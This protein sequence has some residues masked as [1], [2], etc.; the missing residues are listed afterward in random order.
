VASVDPSKTVLNS[1]PPTVIIEEMLVDGKEMDVPP[2]IGAPLVTA[3]STPVKV[4]PGRHYVQFRFT[5]LSF[6]APDG[7]RFRVK[8]EGG[9]D[10][11]QD[12][13][14]R[15]EIGYGPLLPGSYRFR[16]MA[17]NDDGVWNQEG[18]SFAFTVLPNYWETRW[19]K[20]GLAL[21][22]LAVFATT[23]ASIQRQRYRRRLER[24]ERQREMEQERAR[25]ARDLHDDLGTS[26]TQIS[27]LTAL[28]NR[29]S[30][31][32][33]EARELIG[34]VHGRAREMVIALDEI[35]WAV[36]PKNDSL[37]GLVSYLGHFAEEFFRASD[38]RF[39]LDI[40]SELPAV[41]LAAETRHHLFLA[42][43]EALNNAA[44]HSG[45]TQVSVRAE[46]FPNQAA[47]HVEDNGHGFE[48]KPELPAGN[49]LANMNRRLEQIG[50]RIEIKSAPGRGTSVTF[51]VP[52]GN[53]AIRN[54]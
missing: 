46:I 38:I 53:E 13:G 16:V 10:N 35:V 25:I 39:R 20:I 2:R 17:C 22:T 9:G 43:K 15:R 8:L 40:P 41:P 37:A 21:V 49:G 42:F 14:P 3:R 7:V 44:R 4:L 54:S 29:E 24:I 18:D 50:G 6:A 51:Y 34:E 45:A 52:L 12:V 23:A 27:F 36:N 28:A 47:I 5:G 1:I 19:F 48:T 33:S 30:T 32:A 11:W 31:V 26:L